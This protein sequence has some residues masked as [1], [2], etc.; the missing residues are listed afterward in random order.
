MA[1][2]GGLPNQ[3]SM[4]YFY[5]PTTVAFGKNEFLKIWGNRKLEDNWR[6][7]NKGN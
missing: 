6:W 1:P 3:E 5:N 4:F 2:R 7:S